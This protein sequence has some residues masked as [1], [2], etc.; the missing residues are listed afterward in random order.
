[1]TAN[2]DEAFGGVSRLDPD[3]IAMRATSYWDASPLQ[4]SE[5]LLP[6]TTED[7]S[8]ILTACNAAGQTVV[9]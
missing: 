6:R 7:V 2:L 3:D 4:A 8:R 9:V 1:M 5:I